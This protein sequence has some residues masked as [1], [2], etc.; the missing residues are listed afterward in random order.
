M[1][2]IGLAQLN[3]HQLEKPLVTIGDDVK[4]IS[5][6]LRNGKKSFSAQDVIST[7]IGI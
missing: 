5:Q 4:N 1:A 2:N 6:F 3:E 7:I